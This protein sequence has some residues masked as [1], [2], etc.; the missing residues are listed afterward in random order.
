MARPGAVRPDQVELD[1][2]LGHGDRDLVKGEDYTV[3][4]DRLTLTAD[5]LSRLA[6]D[7]EYGVNATLEAGFSRGVPWRIDVITYD[8]PVLS[9]AT[10]STGSYAIPTRFRGDMLATMEARYHD[11]SNAGR[12]DW[13]PYQ[14][15]DTAFSAYTGDSI[16]LTPDFF[17]AVKDGSRVTLTF[18]FWSGA[19]VTYHV[20]RTGTSVTGTA[21]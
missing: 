21:A 4:G 20:T 18:G 3:S 5:A 2:P 13:T 11:G 12:A 7:R 15:W 9:N 10:G 1:H 16:K 17:N 19:S 8:P 6:G 14:Q